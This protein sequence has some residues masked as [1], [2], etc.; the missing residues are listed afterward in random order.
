MFRPM[1]DE[2]ESGVKFWKFI[3]E[4]CGYSLLG[5]RF[6]SFYFMDFV[7]LTTSKF[8]YTVN[9]GGDFSASHIRF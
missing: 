7:A 9:A 5:K 2:V 1:F 8:V 4:L 3:W 6:R